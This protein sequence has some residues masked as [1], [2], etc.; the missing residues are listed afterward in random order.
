MSH[1]VP[2][3]LLLACCVVGLVLVPLGLP[4]LWLMVLGVLGYGWL[5]AF[6]SVGMGILA[7]VAGLALLGEV[8]EWW[9]G[10]RFAE[11]YGGSRRAGWGALVG[12]LVGAAIGVPIPIVGSVIGA[13]VGSFVGAALLEYTRS[14]RAGVAVS[15]GWGAVLG[16]GAAAAVKVALGLVIAVI[17]VLALLRT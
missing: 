1:V 7:L 14:A 16:R 17:G 2:T 9:F 12:G 3:V 8:I 5:T 6:R 10:F 13:F 15:A 4:G 11:R